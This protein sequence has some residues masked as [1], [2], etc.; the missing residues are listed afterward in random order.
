MYIR[1]V[2]VIVFVLSLPSILEHSN[3][4][5]LFLD[6]EPELPKLLRLNITQAVADK[7]ESFGITLLNDTDG[8]KMSII[9]HDCGGKAEAI[10]LSILREWLRADDNCTWRSVITALWQCRS[11]SA[12][13]LAH[14]META[15]NS[16]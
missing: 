14:Q 4:F 1:F 2:V 12:S 11:P 10:T 8:S 16:Q 3:D 6:G 13:S 5:N 9:K 7:Y 15:L